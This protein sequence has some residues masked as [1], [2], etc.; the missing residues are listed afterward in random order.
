MN[1][2]AHLFLSEAEAEFRLGN[3]LPDFL[4]L[5]EL[6]ALPSAFHPGIARHRMIDAFT[7][8][9]AVVRRSIRRLRRDQ[10]RF[11]GIIVDLAYDH[12]LACHWD[13]FATTPLT[14]FTREFYGQMEAYRSL[15]PTEVL[16]AFDLMREEDWLCSY[17]EVAG[18]ADTLRR[19]GNRFRRPVN[20]AAAMEEI[21]NDRDGFTADFLEFF[22]DLRQHVTNSHSPFARQP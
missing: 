17:R 15:L 16:H 11:G 19:V 20:L 21:E 14:V 8:S 22:P 18:L 9:H 10:Q 3:L 2:L 7:D 4:G 1:W 13:R 12:F 6:S 5:H